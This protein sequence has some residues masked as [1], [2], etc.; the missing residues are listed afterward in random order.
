MISHIFYHGTDSRNIDSILREGLIPKK[1]PGADAWA[2]RY[3]PD[4]SGNTKVAHRAPSV[5][6]AKTP[7]HARQF[8]I[9]AADVNNTDKGAIFKIT[10]PTTEIARLKEDEID[11]SWG[12][13]FEGAIPPSWITHH[14]TTTITSE[15][16]Q[17]RKSWTVD[18]DPLSLLIES[19]FAPKSYQQ[20]A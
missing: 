13:R 14:T 12:F 2:N 15:E 8:A 1:S 20:G 7:S 18:P 6:L 19:L 16:K 17:A 5:F 10:V 4:I 3:A 9:Y 11:T